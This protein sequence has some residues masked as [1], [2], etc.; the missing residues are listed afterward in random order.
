MFGQG[1]DLTLP[2]REQ[3]GTRKRVTESGCEDGLVT[4]WCSL[5]NLG[6]DLTQLL[7]SGVTLGKS[8]PS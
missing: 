5:V 2:V 1:H 6:S 8:L 7:V 4:Q 3:L